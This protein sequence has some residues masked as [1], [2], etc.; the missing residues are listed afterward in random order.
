[1]SERKAPRAESVAGQK[2]LRP[3]LTIGSAARPV[4]PSRRGSPMEIKPCPQKEGC[5]A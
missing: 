2:I 5:K 3:A 1:M 4:C